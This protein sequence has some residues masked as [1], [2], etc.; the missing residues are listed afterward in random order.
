[1]FIWAILNIG[2]PKKDVT[3][4]AKIFW[5]NLQLQARWIL[6]SLNALSYSAWDTPNPQGKK[7]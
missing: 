7:N 2:Q 5:K 3:K 4:T 6:I 1:M